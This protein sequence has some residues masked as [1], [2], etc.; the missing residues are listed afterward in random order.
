MKI[1][2]FTVRQKAGMSLEMLADKTGIAKITL[3]KIEKEIIPP[4]LNQLELIAN[5]IECEI[6]DLFDEDI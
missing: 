6:S 2:V 5:A 4:R 3:D 1:L